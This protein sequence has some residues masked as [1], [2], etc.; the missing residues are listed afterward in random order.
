MDQNRFSMPA[1]AL[2]LYQTDKDVM[3]I[4]EHEDYIYTAYIYNEKYI[5]NF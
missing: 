5:R 2:K 1:Y 4:A 3:Y